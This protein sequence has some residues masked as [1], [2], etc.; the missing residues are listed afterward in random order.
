MIHHLNA[1][2]GIV[3]TLAVCASVVMIAWA[4]A[5]MN[6]AALLAALISMG[7]LAALSAPRT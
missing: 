3:A 5:Q 7:V 1:T 4:L 6:P 2:L